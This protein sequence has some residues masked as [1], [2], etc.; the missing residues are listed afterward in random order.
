MTAWRYFQHPVTLC[1]A[2]VYRDDHG[3]AKVYARWNWR[4]V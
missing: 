2:R 4:E 1:V 3:K